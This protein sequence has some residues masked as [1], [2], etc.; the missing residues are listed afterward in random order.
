MKAIVQTKYGSTDELTLMD[1]PIPTPIKKQVR[2]KVQAAAINDYD[3]CMVSGKPFIYRLMF[4]LFKPKSS[5]PGMEIAGEIEACG[6]DAKLFNVGDVVFGDL[7]ECGFGGF[8]E[9]VC[10]DE[11]ALFKKPAEM[12]FEYAAALPHAA[13][14]ALQGLVDVGKITSDEKVLINGA[15]GGV[16]ASGLNIAKLYNAHVTA[17]DTGHK[18]T[19]LRQSGFDE[20]L[21][22]QKTDFTQ[23]SKQYD[24]ILDAK[25]NRSIFQYLKVLSPGGRYVTVGG[26]LMRLVQLLLLKPWVTLFTNKRISIVALKANKDLATICT[27]YTAKKLVP[28]LDLREGLSTVPDAIK[29]FGAGMH[30]GKLVIKL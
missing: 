24:I 12:S 4:G 28:V 30:K 2:V 21:D 11:S 7:S 6:E 5:I 26:N 9:Y 3:W 23:Q 22:Y 17:V 19:M 25:T 20:V 14:L 8:A 29:T 13:C 1:V 15:G 18:L 10:I 16:G 27:W